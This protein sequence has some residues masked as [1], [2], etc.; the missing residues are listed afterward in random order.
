MDNLDIFI[1]QINKAYTLAVATDRLS[2]EQT[3]LY[4]NALAGEARS[5]RLRPR[6]RFRRRLWRNRVAKM[7]NK[8]FNTQQKPSEIDWSAIWQF[9][10]ENIIPILQKLL[11]L[12]LL[13]I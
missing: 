2:A 6:T 10:L 3:Q 4:G 13:F 1:G 12:T 5:Y 8:A 9:I 11:P 7:V